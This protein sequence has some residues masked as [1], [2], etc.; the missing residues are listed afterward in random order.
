[1]SRSGEGVRKDVRESSWFDSKQKILMTPL[2]KPMYRYCPEES[3][4]I[5][6]GFPW[7]VV[8]FRLHTLSLGDF[9]DQSADEEGVSTRRRCGIW[10][11]S[12]HG[13]GER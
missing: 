10:R 8:E 11:Q 13:G 4:R 1:M 9:Q 7:R 3:K 5:I 2:S 12:Y 6:D